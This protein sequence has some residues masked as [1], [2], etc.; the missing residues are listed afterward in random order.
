MIVENFIGGDNSFW[1]LLIFFLLMFL[2]PKIY[3]NQIIWKLE[4][5]LKE[6]EEYTKKTKKIALKKL[7][8]TDKIKKELL[9]NFMDFFISFPVDLDPYGIVK[10]IDH[11]MDQSE[12][13]FDYVVERLA[14]A[15][16]TKEERKDLKFT[17]M[18]AL[19]TNQIFKVVRHYILTIKKTNNL[20]LAMILQMSMPMLMEIARAQVK[21]TKAFSDNIPIGDAIGPLLAS[22]LKQK[23]GKE[24]AKEVLVSEEKINGVKV[25]VMKADGPGAALGKMGLAVEKAVNKHKINHIITVDAAAKLE[26]EKTGKIAQGVGVMMGGI[27][28]TR[29]KIEDVAVKKDIPLDGVVVK[30][31]PEEASI[32]MKKEI[33][34]ALPKLADTVKEIVKE[35]KNK[36]ILIIGVGNTCGIGDKKT[37]IYNLDKKMKP[38]WAQQKKEEESKKK[39]SLFKKTTI[40]EDV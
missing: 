21:A 12:R 35:N 8:K 34:K 32:P 40:M 25:W 14:P 2:Y 18:G 23:N 26:G 13:R 38:V 28:T 16:F 6:L 4:A 27:G 24:Y 15:K 39:K 37:D 33:F 9:D 30:M 31:S 36:R 29:Y 22:S 1:S 7:G 17:L 10:K 19:G 11:I 20:Q 5:Q 3:M